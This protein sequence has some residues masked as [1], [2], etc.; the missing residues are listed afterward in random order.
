MAQNSSKK[1]NLAHGKGNKNHRKG[2]IFEFR[3][4][5]NLK[6]IVIGLFILFIAFSL[7]GSLGQQAATSLEKPLSTVISDVKDG[8]VTKIEVEESRLTVHY[9]DGGKF[10]SHKEPQE[11]MFKLLES[12]GIDSKS[13]EIKV[14]DLS[15]GQLWLGIISNILPLGLT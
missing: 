15:F 14:K 13:V 2:K 7:L 8:K 9:K 3:L 10:I 12:S 5:F 4:D 6:N 1:T 11:S